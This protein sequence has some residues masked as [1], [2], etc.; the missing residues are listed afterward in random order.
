MNQ[1]PPSSGERS[2]LELRKL[3]EDFLT[4][5]YVYYNSSPLMTTLK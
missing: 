3:I 5:V 4:R 1:H 2:I